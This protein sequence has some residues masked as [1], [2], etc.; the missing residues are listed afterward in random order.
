VISYEKVKECFNA[1][2]GNYSQPNLQTNKAQLN[3]IFSQDY[4]SIAFAIEPTELISI[5]YNML[6]WDLIQD[7]FIY[8][9]SLSVMYRSL[10]QVLLKPL[11]FPVATICKKVF[12][13]VN[14]LRKSRIFSQSK[15]I[16]AFYN[17]FNSLGEN[18][19]VIDPEVLREYLKPFM[20]TLQV[21]LHQEMEMAQEE[22]Q[23]NLEKKSASSF[24]K[25]FEELFKV[26]RVRTL[27]INEEELKEP[28]VR[29]VEY[30]NDRLQQTTF[31][32]LRA[33]QVVHQTLLLYGSLF[34]IIKYP[35]LNELCAASIPS[36]EQTALV[37]MLFSMLFMASKQETISQEFKLSM[38]GILSNCSRMIEVQSEAS[39][40]PSDQDYYL[41]L[42]FKMHFDQDA[43]FGQPANIE[44]AMCLAKL[45]KSLL[46]PG[47][48][49]QTKHLNKMSKLKISSVIRLYNDM[50]AQ[51]NK[52]NLDEVPLRRLLEVLL[53]IL[54]G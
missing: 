43:K 26:S 23:R 11:N 32:Y 40:F 34:T 12:S 10:E 53:S 42:Y 46:T 38:E 45:V 52:M 20:K 30:L 14:H 19:R 36:F 17:A 25:G 15:F 33:P 21:V 2:E 51:V 48:G 1:L 8:F 27:F 31:S 22:E 44:F 39:I 3:T 5:T 13:L 47:H 18:I 29:L 37:K 6:L 4:E 7:E 49:P 54:K 50:M 9:N 28:L 16:S 41:E 24:L 35:S